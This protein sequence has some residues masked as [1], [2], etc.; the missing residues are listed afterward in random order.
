MRARLARGLP[1]A[2]ALAV[3]GTFCWS[4]L[5]FIAHDGMLGGTDGHFSR[6]VNFWWFL[7][8]FEPEFLMRF[9]EPM[10]DDLGPWGAER[11]QWTPYAPMAWLSTATFYQVHGVS[12][13]AARASQ[14]PWSAVLLLGAWLAG[15]RLGGPWTGLQAVALVAG[16]PVLL[17]T[18]RVFVLDWAGAGLVAL[19]LG[20]AIPSLEGR[21][22]AALAGLAA[23]GAILAKSTGL[24]VLA[25]P[26]AFL[27]AH[28]LWRDRRT[29]AAVAG[30][31]AIAVI[32]LGAWRAVVYATDPATWHAGRWLREWA[33]F[34]AVPSVLLAGLAARRP[35]R[36]GA[37]CA[38]VAAT[39]LSASPWYWWNL[40]GVLA[41][42]EFVVNH[43][44]LTGHAPALRVTRSVLDE[45]SVLGV[46][47]LAVAAGLLPWGDH[48][49]LRVVCAGWALT[50]VAS[51]TQ[52]GEAPRLL[53]ATGAARVLAPPAALLLIALSP[54]LA[55]WRCAEAPV[56]LLLSALA[57]F[58]AT[59]WRTVIGPR[60]AT[61]HALVETW[62][63]LNLTRGP[64][65]GESG[66][67]AMLAL[68]GLPPPKVDRDTA[69]VLPASFPAIERDMFYALTLGRT[70]RRVSVRYDG[71]DGQS[72]LTWL[73]ERR[74]ILGSVVV[75][76]GVSET[77]E[78]WLRSWAGRAPKVV[79]G[80]RVPMTLRCYGGEC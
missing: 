72:A 16:A 62:R 57:A 34:A 51:A 48:R 9:G 66:D 22:R 68:W 67:A 46:G 76:G 36:S 38:F 28:A 52:T 44:E 29:L 64:G 47:A 19:A 77:V 54:S 4:Q 3:A 80:H 30:P 49:A 21:L 50:L 32:A 59:S 5:D 27:V 17:H 25:V 35:G 7:R 79:Y 39:V 33:L 37:A 75:A 12:L 41:A 56:A 13:F 78:D 31:G 69:F 10:W 45:M 2:V 74:K 43:R 8:T 55:R 26:A 23:G 71:R 11:P 53:D 20:L 18:S 24:V 42:G 60:Q 15:S 40:D 1:F 70:G 63:G 61:E 73:R 6:S 14:A 65:R 58:S